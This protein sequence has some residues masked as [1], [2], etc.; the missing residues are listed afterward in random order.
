MH[1]AGPRSVAVAYRPSAAWWLVLA[2]AVLPYLGSLGGEMVAGDLEFIAD[3]PVMRSPTI[4]R[5]AFTHSYWYA[6]D[7]QAKAPYYRPLVVLLDWFDHARFGPA[8]AGYHVTNLLLHA[9]CCLLVLCL[10]RQV[11][12]VGPAAVIAAVAF[13]VHPIHVHSVA[14]ISGRTSMLATLFVLPSVGLAIESARRAQAG[15]SG[16]WVARVGAAL[17]AALALLAKESAAPLPALSAGALLLL[18]PEPRAL[19]R[20]H[21]PLLAMLLCVVLAYLALRGTVLGQLGSTRK[22]L[23]YRLDGVSAVLSMAKIVGFY[24]QKLLWPGGLSYLPPFVP[25]LRPSDAAGIAWLGVLGLTTGW[26]LYPTGRHGMARYW[27][28]WLLASLLPVCGIFSLEYFV[29]EHHAYLP[30]VGFCM[31]L[32]LGCARLF[33]GFEARGRATGVALGWAVLALSGLA[34]G[35][36]TAVHARTFSGQR[37]LYGR[38]VALE[39]EIPEAAFEHLA[40]N[41]SAH[42]FALS[43]INLGLLDLKAGDCPGALPHFERAT[44]LARHPSLRYDA[45]LLAADCETRMGRSGAAGARLRRL[46]EADETRPEAASVLA[47]LAKASGDSAG[48][49]RLRALACARGARDACPR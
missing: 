41:K 32:G 47:R 10:G 37:A 5:D 17:L 16:E 21:W 46:M 34:L 49:A 6:G 18:W 13:A 1:H 48:A 43:R 44:V 23:W 14:Y 3:N 38:V 26:V 27:T 7:A 28:F 39:G 8:P 20:R 19:L 4:V 24:P 42:R 22:P 15:R 2:A 9:L 36:A 31:L 45:H 35:G 29:K 12:P 33:A 11:L 25:A 40:M 30:A